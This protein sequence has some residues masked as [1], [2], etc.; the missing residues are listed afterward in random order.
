MEFDEKELERIARSIRANIINMTSLAG[1]GH[2]G[3]SFSIVEI[4]TTLYFWKMNIRRNEPD[5]EDR[6][7]FVL[8]KGHAAPAL[9][10]TLIE[11][12]IYD[13]GEI[14]NFRKIGSPFQGHPDGKNPG[15]DATT[16]SLG[17]GLSQAV[18]MALGAKQKSANFKIYALLGD[19]ECD[20]GQI[21]EAALFAHHH[22]LD[23]LVVFLDHNGDQF[24][25]KV[26]EVM[27]LSPLLQ[28]WEAFGWEVHQFKGHEFKQ[29]INFLNQATNQNGKP[30]IG[31][32]ETKK[33]YGV[34][35]MEGN[36]TFHARSLTEEETER[37]LAELQK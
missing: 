9:Y 37:A 15:I 18:G 1:S 31:I 27:S 28:K 23:N 14:F 20:E 12:G 35:F 3:P 6:D 17:I 24:E 13:P 2:P 19:G 29:I 7:R 21:W 4:L 26:E 22:K 16:G 36:H 32:A 10:A 33:G 5:W 8:S 25:G 30:K 34:T 11:K